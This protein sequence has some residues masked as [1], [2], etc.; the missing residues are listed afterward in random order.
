KV[1]DLCGGPAAAIAKINHDAGSSRE[2]AVAIPESFDDCHAPRIRIAVRLASGKGVA[3][4]AN[5][6]VAQAATHWQGQHSENG[7]RRGNQ[8]TKPAEKLCAVEASF[9]A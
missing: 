8:E 5:V 3:T 2:L 6:R 9:L 1:S 4:I 7:D